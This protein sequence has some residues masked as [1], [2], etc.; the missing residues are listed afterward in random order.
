MLQHKYLLLVLKCLLT[1]RKKEFLLHKLFAMY[2]ILNRT[3]S[4]QNS[5]IYIVLSVESEKKFS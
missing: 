3:G 1:L 2:C 5:E 4:D